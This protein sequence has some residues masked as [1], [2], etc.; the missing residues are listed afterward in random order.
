VACDSSSRDIPALAAGFG[1]SPDR[2]AADQKAA[3]TSRQ[4]LAIITECQSGRTVLRLRGELGADNW[5][6]LRLAI[7]NALECRPR[8]LVIDLAAVDF[9]DCGGLAV[10][11]SAHQQLA[12]QGCDLIITAAQ[13]M[14]SRLICLTGL[15]TYLHIG[16]RL[17]G[18]GT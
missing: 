14:V 17:G 2:K 3:E 9:A 1:D 10:L 12:Q 5:D 15:D 11:V 8:I 6:R 16:G 18:G 4:D 13:P 7:R